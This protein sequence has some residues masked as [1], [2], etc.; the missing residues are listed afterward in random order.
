MG[1]YWPNIRE[2]EKRLSGLRKYLRENVRNLSCKEEGKLLEEVDA[3]IRDLEYAKLLKGAKTQNYP[4]DTP[5]HVRE[6]K[7]KFPGPGK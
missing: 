5:L 6:M 4:P 2:I 1:G 3:V 7:T